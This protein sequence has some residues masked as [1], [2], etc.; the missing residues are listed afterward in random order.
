[1]RVNLVREHGVEQ[2]FFDGVAA[3]ADEMAARLREFCVN[4]PEPAPDRMFSEV[5]AEPSPLVE[6]Q[7]EEFLAYH[8]SFAA[9]S[10]GEE[11]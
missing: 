2:E 11:G 1:M 6:A 3:E 8:A 9:D 7:R 5:Y 10:G 4:M